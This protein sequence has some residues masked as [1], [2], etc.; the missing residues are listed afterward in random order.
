VKKTQERAVSNRLNAGGG[1]LRQQVA[2]VVRVVAG[3]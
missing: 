2:G 3:G 1:Q